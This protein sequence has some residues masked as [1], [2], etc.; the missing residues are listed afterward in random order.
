M[1]IEG[2]LN[3]MLQQLIPEAFAQAINAVKRAESTT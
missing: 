3:S 1:A 2:E